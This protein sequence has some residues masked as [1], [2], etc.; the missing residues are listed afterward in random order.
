METYGIVPGSVDTIL[1]MQVLC[2]VE[3]PEEVLRYLYTL[4][5]PGGRMVVYEHV[6]NEDWVSRIV[7][8]GYSSF[9]R[10]FS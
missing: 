9:P 6:Q 8:C 2:S 3:K 5:K 1:S 7:Q 10:L 4:L